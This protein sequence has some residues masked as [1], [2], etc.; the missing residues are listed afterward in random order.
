MLH[1]RAAMVGLFSLGMLLG[2]CS[3]TPPGSNDGGGGNSG[4]GGQKS[5]SGGASGNG[6]A[7]SGTGG[8]LTVGGTGGVGQNDARVDAPDTTDASTG[9]GGAKGTDG[10]GAND[11]S[12]CPLQ[13]PT[14]TVG[15][16]G[17][18][19]PSCSNA[20]EICDYRSA[21]CKCGPEPTL[22]GIDAGP[23]LVWSCSPIL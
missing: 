22:L 17:F 23:Q 21:L 2:A 9:S 13:E 16:G 14:L 6:A 5:G 7:G 8:S 20:G 15:D 18:V 10:G 19:Y 12:T 4:S 11:A 1:A 3:A